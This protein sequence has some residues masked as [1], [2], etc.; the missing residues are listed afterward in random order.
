MQI[1]ASPAFL[2]NPSL[3]GLTCFSHLPSNSLP[4]QRCQGEEAIPNNTYKKHG[5]QGGSVAVEHSGTIGSKGVKS[6]EDPYQLSWF[7]TR[8]SSDGFTCRRAP[9]IIGC[10]YLPYETGEPSNYLQVS[11]PHGFVTFC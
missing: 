4:Q 8:D 5:M 11:Q 10:L 2:I 1:C 7:R 3:E 9:R 6:G